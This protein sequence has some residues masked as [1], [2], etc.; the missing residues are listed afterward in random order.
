MVNPLRGE[1]PITINGEARILRLSLGA[2]IAFEAERGKSIMALLEA[3]DRGELEIADLIS[4]LQAGLNASGWSVT[5]DTLLEAE[6]EGG[7]LSATRAVANA[8]RLSFDPTSGGGQDE[9]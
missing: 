5:R 4:L 2:L 6:F 3:L 9:L 8:L 1:V 7:Y